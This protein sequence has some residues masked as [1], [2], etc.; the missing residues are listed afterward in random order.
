MTFTLQLHPTRGIVIRDVLSGKEEACFS[1][2]DI[3]SFQANHS[4]FWFTTC[5]CGSSSAALYFFLVC[6]G[7]TACLSLL[8]ELKQCMLLHPKQSCESTLLPSEDHVT[9]VSVDRHWRCN[10]PRRLDP[11]KLGMRLSEA[12]SH[13]AQEFQTSCASLGALGTQPYWMAMY[14]W[15]SSR[16]TH[17]RVLILA[18]IVQQKTCVYPQ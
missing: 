14:Q 17:Q 9:T 15:T 6:S 10:F 13:C 7:E 8:M 11:L 2:D 18:C 12:C 3:H 1:Y 16:N 5:A 4:I